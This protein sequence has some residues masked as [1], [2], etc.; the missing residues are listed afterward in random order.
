MGDPALPDK[1]AAAAILEQFRGMVWSEPIYAEFVLRQMPRRG[2]ERAY[3][4]RFWGG[5][6]E[7]GPVTRIELDLDGNG[8]AHRF[9]VFWLPV[10][11]VTRAASM[12]F[13]LTR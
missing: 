3:Q 11:M 4:G 10:Y 12:P 9:L 2:P 6:N 13:S 8:Y 7:Q 1:P 5:R